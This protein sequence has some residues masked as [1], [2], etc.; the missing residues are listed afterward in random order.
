MYSHTK[1]RLLNAILTEKGEGLC[2]TLNLLQRAALKPV[3]SV[4]RTFSHA[5]VKRK[6]RTS[7]TA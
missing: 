6:S 4:N 5:L 3:K 2:P 1:H 7:A